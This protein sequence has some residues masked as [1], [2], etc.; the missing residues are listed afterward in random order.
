MLLCGG[1]IFQDTAYNLVRV[2]PHMS[3]GTSETVIG[4]SYFKDWIWNLARV[5]AKN[6][7]SDNGIFVSL[8]IFVLTVVRRDSHKLSM[9]SVQSIIMA[10]LSGLSRPYAIGHGL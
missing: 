9:V 1:T 5:L 4:K 6:Y 2:Q 8:I 3:Q 7:Q 10:R